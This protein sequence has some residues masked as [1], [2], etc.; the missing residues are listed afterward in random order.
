MQRPYFDVS[1]TGVACAAFGGALLIAGDQMTRT[2]A[3]WAYALE[4]LLASYA[5]FGFMDLLWL[6]H[7]NNVRQ[8]SLRALQEEEDRRRS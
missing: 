5:L 6:G 7:K 4:V 8:S 2:W 1:V 3:A